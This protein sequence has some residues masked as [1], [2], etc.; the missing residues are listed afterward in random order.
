MSWKT[1]IIPVMG[2]FVLIGFFVLNGCLGIGKGISVQETLK[3]LPYDQAFDVA[4]RSAEKM[5]E[6]CKNINPFNFPVIVSLGTSKSRGVITVHYR[7]DPEAGSI[8]SK[9]PVDISSSA[10]RV[11]VPHFGAEFYMHIR[12][13]KEGDKAKAVSI[14]I[15]QSK[16][17]K[18]DVFDKEMERFKDVYK[19]YLNKEYSVL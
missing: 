6:E 4:L 1:M 16:G 11:F 18:K 9:P 5:C 19:N 7:F 17:V 14:E 12:I 15:T 10:K 2:I 3:P 8:C 13:I